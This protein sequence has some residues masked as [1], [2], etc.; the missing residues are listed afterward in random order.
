MTGLIGV[1]EVHAPERS[2][3]VNV[4][5]VGRRNGNRK[6][7]CFVRNRVEESV[8][9]RKQRHER[10]RRTVSCL[11]SARAC[12]NVH[13]IIEGKRARVGNVQKREVQAVRVHAHV[14][15]PFHLPSL[16]EVHD[17]SEAVVLVFRPVARRVEAHDRK[18]DDVIRVGL[19][20]VL[21]C[22]VVAESH[23]LARREV[24]PWVSRSVHSPA[25]H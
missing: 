25:R 9:L 23:S 24:R 3:D 11:Q 5:T 21:D 20:P 15:R 13:W 4:V 7:V 6:A 2:V 22:N 8:A 19:V 12:R 16:V 1:A 18:L 10:F 14:I 17:I